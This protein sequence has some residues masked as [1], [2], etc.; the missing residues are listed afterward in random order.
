MKALSG[1]AILFFGLQCSTLFSAATG[2]DNTT[3][4]TSGGI[5]QQSVRLPSTICQL[6]NPLD[7]LKN[8]IS[9]NTL[10]AAAGVNHDLAEMLSMLYQENGYG[11]YVVN[12]TDKMIFWEYMP[13]FTAVGMHLAFNTTHVHLIAGMSLVWW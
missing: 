11:N 12:Q 7:H 8:N 3:W 4:N 10:Q 13:T 2:S 9:E 1:T 5:K 6:F